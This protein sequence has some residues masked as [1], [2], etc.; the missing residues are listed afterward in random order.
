MS[1]VYMRD[2]KPYLDY[3]DG[4]KRV[5][6]IA[7]G[8]RTK[9]QAKA[10]LVEIESSINRAKVDGCALDNHAYIKGLME[11]YLSHKKLYTNKVKTYRDYERDAE[12]I[13]AELG[14]LLV[15]DITLR[16]V[17]NWQRGVVDDG[18]CHNTANKRLIQLKNMLDYGVERGILHSNP[19]A[20]A[21]PLP[22]KRIKHRRALSVEECRRLISVSSEPWR[23][24]WL[25][26]LNTGMRLMELVNLD[27]RDIDL[28]RRIIIVR[29]KEDGSVKTEAGE[30][31]IPMND[32]LLEVMER[33][34]GEATA[35]IVF[36]TERG[37]RRK[38]NMLRTLKSHLKEAGIEVD[39]TVDIHALRYTFI[40]ELICNG[41]DPKTVQTIAG[42]KSIET[43]LKIYAQCRTDMTKN[44]VEKLPN[45]C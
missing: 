4:T 45:F 29:E 24:I 37:T 13:V 1:R 17:E 43:T 33:L 9:A 6:C 21:K 18:L 23:S 36:P 7:K 20:G 10:M 5:R 42:H 44:A 3:H 8:C 11:E 22:V 40:T 32:R 12:R 28:D 31:A 25:T 16:A 35:D 27:W 30:R 38:N 14:V 19:I 39:G 2:G 15:S 26:Y 34:K 41:V